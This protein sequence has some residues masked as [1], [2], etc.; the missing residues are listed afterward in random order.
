LKSNS[1]FSTSIVMLSHSNDE[2]LALKCIEMG[3][4]DFVMKNEISSIRLRRAII[5][6]TERYF[7]EQKVLETHTQLKQL[8]ETDTLT[9][10]FNR[11][12]FDKRLKKFLLMAS[13]SQTPLALLLIDVDRFKDINDQYGHVTGDHVLQEVAQRLQCNT[14][15]SDSLF[16]IGGDEFAVIATNLASEEQVDLIV[17]RILSAFESN[18]N[19]DQQCIEVSI[20]IGVASYPECASNSLE[21]RKC[22]DIALYRAKEKGRKQAQYYSK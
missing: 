12:F 20:S 21:L 19:I 5:I 14:R 16:R 13:R 9:G 4:Q 6:A 1:D 10:V 17:R 8:A 7:L 15:D 2:E 18:F 11:H 3:A 22:S